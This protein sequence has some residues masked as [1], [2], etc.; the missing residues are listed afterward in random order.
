MLFLS[1]RVNSDI[2]FVG[3]ATYIIDGMIHLYRIY[4]RTNRSWEHKEV[5]S[6]VFT[7]LHNLDDVA[8]LANVEIALFRIAHLSSNTLYQC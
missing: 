8:L 1:N 5:T 3:I 4:M 7:P 2:P 6:V